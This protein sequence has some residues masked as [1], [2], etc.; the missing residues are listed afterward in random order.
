MGADTS[1]GRHVTTQWYMYCTISPRP[2]SPPGLQL[3]ASPPPVGGE[4]GGL[5]GSENDVVDIGSPSPTLPPGTNMPAVCGCQSTWLGDGVC[6]DYGAS[7]NCNV[8]ECNYDNGDCLT[9][10]P[11]P[12]SPPAPPPSNCPCPTSWLADGVCDATLGCN[13]A[14][15]NYDG[16]DCT[17][18]SPPPAM[19]AN[20][21]CPPEWIGDGFCDTVAT[22]MKDCNTAQC[23][24]DGGDCVTS[25]PSESPTTGGTMGP[26]CECPSSWLGDG[27]CDAFYL[28]C[29]S[30][31][32]Q[33]EYA[34]ADMRHPNHIPVEGHDRMRPDG[35]HDRMRLDG[36]HTIACAL[37]AATRSHAP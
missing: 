31:E 24:F 32:C 7:G 5:T 35:G 3:V 36:G 15:C 30:A 17:G 25:P 10:P 13:V 6:D 19:G 8:A 20:C 22:S 27:A 9:S 1:H 2:P 37:M 18:A 26:A 33:S 14:D 34:Q 28:N 29:N 23:S 11:S 4:G 21:D 12:P 16:G